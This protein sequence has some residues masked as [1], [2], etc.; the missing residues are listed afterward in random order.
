[1][2]HCKKCDVIKELSEFNN[3]SGTPD[4]KQYQCRACERINHQLHYAKTKATYVANAYRS[5]Q[6]R[7]EKFRQWKATHACMLCGENEIVCIDFHHLDPEHK[8]HKIST[9]SRDG[10]TPKLLIEVKKC[11]PVC[12]NC[13]RKI[14]KYGYDVDNNRI[15]Y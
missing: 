12:S 9:L 14:H 2:K 3:K 8:D 1:M 6:L 7:I 4:G 13:H 5:R 11:I 15:M 10:L